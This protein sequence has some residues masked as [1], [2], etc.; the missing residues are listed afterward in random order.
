ML[1]SQIFDS[2]FIPSEAPRKSLARKLMIVL[3]GR[4]D[5]LDPF[6]E[7][8][9]ELGLP[10][11]N[12]LLVNAPR[13][14]LDGYT[15]Y[16]FPPHQA[17][18]VL[19]ARARLR[20]LLDELEEQGWNSR[21]I[22]LFG[23]SQ[24]A[25]VGAD[26]LMHGGRPLAGVIG[27]SGYIYHFP[28]WQRNLSPYARKIPWLMTHGLQ[29]DALDIEETRQHVAAIKAHDIPLLWRE[30]NK[31]HEIEARKEIPFLRKW[32]RSHA[33][34]S[35]MIPEGLEGLKSLESL[36]STEGLRNL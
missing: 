18:G 8:N 2:E 32:I 17:H 30:F 34:I 29:D 1:T 26:F 11:M 27:V 10:E 24:G 35:E 22:F 14:Y 33:H 31:G 12:Y 20:L 23:F 16:A 25:L 28:Q 15:W 6:R 9:Y 7:F 36:R 21:D 3:H 5:S 19:K 4:G 13:K